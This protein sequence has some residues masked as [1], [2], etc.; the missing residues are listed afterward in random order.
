MGQSIL[1]YKYNPQF[2]ASQ[3]T[4]E[5]LELIFQVDKG[6]TNNMILV[7]IVSERWVLLFMSW[8]VGIYIQMFFSCLFDLF[9]IL[10]F[11]L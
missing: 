6:A 2:E 8:M 7:F 4:T 3:T 5:Q 9:L 10:Q 11:Y 1:Q